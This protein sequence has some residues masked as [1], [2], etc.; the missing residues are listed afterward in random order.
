MRTKQYYNYTVVEF[1]PLINRTIVDVVNYYTDNGMELKKITRDFKRIFVHHLINNICEFC[2]A[3]KVATD[4]I[5]F[6]NPQ[7][8]TKRSEIFDYLEYV[9]F[10][11]FLKRVLKELDGLIPLSI[12]QSVDITF[13]EISERMTTNDLK[14]AFDI[15]HSN[16][17][18]SKS[19]RKI[20]EYSETLGLTFLRNNFLT[21]VP[22][23]KIFI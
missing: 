9:D 19:Y 7:L 16:S 4:K 22:L 12:F 11:L 6:C 14:F 17:H 8:I 1:D 10:V 15:V 13:D 2:M 18:G 5:L 3:S 21:Q 20:S 23:R